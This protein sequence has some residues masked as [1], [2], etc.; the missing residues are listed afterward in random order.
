MS[1]TTPDHQCE[2]PTQITTGPEDVEFIEDF[3]SPTEADGVFSK[4]MAPGAIDWRQDE[5]TLFGRTV[6]IPRLHAWYGDRP[7]TYS[8]M[9]LDPRAWI[10]ELSKVRARLTE[11]L[12]CDF[13]NVLI[14]LYRDGRDSMGWHRDNE[15]ELGSEPVIASLSL[16]AT[17]WFRLRHINR[18][19]NGEPIVNYE[20]TPGSILVMHGQTQRYWEH[21][22]PKLGKAT[23]CGP[24]INL[25]FRKLD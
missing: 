25:T 11:F 8:G 12:G 17:R 23:L 1:H 21:S 22:L 7:Y 14:N 16:G 15:P 3:L 20:L 10:P 2:E 6:R 13:S 19:E 18:A 4:L 9:T 5:I 24:R